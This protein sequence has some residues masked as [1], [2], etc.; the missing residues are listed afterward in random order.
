MSNGAASNRA[1]VYVRVSTVRQADEGYSIAGQVKRIRDYARFRGLSITKRDVIVEE[2]VSGGIPLFERKGGKKMLEMIETRRYSHVIAAKL[3]RMFRMTT[4]TI[5]SL[6]YLDSLEIAIHFVDFG[7]QTVDTSTSTGIFV[8][9]MIAA[10]AQMERDRISERTLESMAYL[11]ENHLKFTRA[12]Y[13]WDAKKDGGI[14]PNWF[15]QDKID[16]MRWQMDFNDIS[17]ANVARS[18]NKRG[19]KGKLGGKWQGN[20]VIRT[21]YNAYHAERNSFPLPKNWGKR[22]W[23]RKRFRA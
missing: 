7:G 6:D 4:D 1:I 2:G 14:K 12:I 20:G 10:L 8:I 15:E 18:L 16:Y 9:T 22:A 23:H 3:D 17:A 19:R 13:G 11:K 21:A 5:H